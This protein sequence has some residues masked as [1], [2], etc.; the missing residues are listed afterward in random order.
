MLDAFNDVNEMLATWKSLFINIVNQHAPIVSRKVKN[1]KLNEWMTAEIMQKIR[2]R[3]QLKSRSK[4]NTLA[5]VMHKRV[6]NHVVKLI[7]N[8]KSNYFKQQIMDN[9]DNVKNLWKILKRVVPIKPLRKQLQQIEVDGK[10]ITDPVE[11]SNAF[12]QYFVSLSQSINLDVRGDNPEMVAFFDNLFHEFIAT[13]STSSSSFFE[14][15]PITKERVELDIKSIPSNKATGLDGISIRLL[16]A[17]LPAISSS[18]ANIYNAS[19]SSKTFP[20]DFKRAKVIPCHKKEST[21]ERGNIRPISILSV[22]SKPLERHVSLSFFEH[23]RS[24]DL[25]YLNQSGFRV[26]HSSETA[27]INITDKWLKAMD[28][29]ELVGA[30]FMDLS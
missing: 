4:S 21:H 25:M 23:L 2:I 1:K 27:L 13:R 28:D 19:I 7:N 22:L 12:N 29:D 20:D 14:I 18:L 9:K 16:K 8:A 10:F 26:N 5:R 24:H 3:D 30:V 11:I 6:R 15:P 17:A